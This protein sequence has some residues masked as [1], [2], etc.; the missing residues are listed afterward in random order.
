MPTMVATLNNVV[1]LRGVL[2]GVMMLNP[3]V[4]VE[5][6]ELSRCELAVVVGAQHTQ[7]VIAL[8]RNSL[9]TLGVCR[10]C[11][12]VNEDLPHVPGHDVDE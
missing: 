3:F 7:L 8:L 9:Y 4:G 12:G 2:R 11:L 1:L 6:C 10:D 5:R